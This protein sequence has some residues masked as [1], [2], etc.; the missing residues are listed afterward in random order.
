MASPTSEKKL[1]G[2][3]IIA[4]ALMLFSM[5]FGAGNLIF[6]PVLGANSGENFTPAII[7]FLLGG[8]AL[9]AITIVAMTLSGNDIR[10]LGSRAGSWFN[11]SFA[12]IAYLSIGAFYAIPRTGAVSYSTVIQPVMSEPSTAASVGFN[13]LFFA[14]ALLLSLNPTGIVDKL[15]KILTPALLILLVILV[16]LA[17]FKLNGTAAPA[18]DSYRE[19]P[20]TSGLLEGYMTM[21]SIAALVF[22]ILV[23][24]S[25]RYQGGNNER[26]VIGAAV[27]ASLIAAGLLGII[28]LGLGYMGHIIP[29]GQGF[30]DGAA[31][32]SSASQQTMGTPGQVIFGLI[33]LLA[34][35]TTA[36]G[37][38]ASTSEFFNRLIPG[39]SY[40]GWLFIFALISF[41]VGSLGLA[42]VLAVAA[43]V[44]TFIYPIAITLVAITV[45]EMLVKN[46]NLF[47]GFRLPAWAVT[48]WSAITVIASDTLAWAPFHDIS[49]SWIWPALIGFV[50]G[51]SIDKALAYKS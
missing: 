13:A 21:D 37:L 24:S 35:M 19:A 29:N 33:V 23:I 48:L 20:L 41:A 12:I 16:T 31:L 10:D 26:Q 14:V 40:K 38:L 43:P 28:Y 25:L 4:T 15:G 22:G 44:I 46:L 1:S 39:I 42:K 51:L 47:W 17:A 45:I 32:L 36:V 6:P 8:V 3:A 27:K 34:C 2:G 9:P 18:T 49:L 30:A 5:F 11:L 50:I 7:G